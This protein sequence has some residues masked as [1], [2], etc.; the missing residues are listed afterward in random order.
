M[1]WWL[2]LCGFFMEAVNLQS[3]HMFINSDYIID[4]YDVKDSTMSNPKILSPLFLCHPYL[5]PSFFNLKKFFLFSSLPSF[6]CMH[7]Y[8]RSRGLIGGKGPKCNFVN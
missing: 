6:L 3:F 4:L 1:A 7:V 2:A 8:I 5:Y